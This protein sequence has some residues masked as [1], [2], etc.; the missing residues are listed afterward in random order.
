VQKGLG[1]GIFNFNGGTLKSGA[2]SATFMTGLTNAYVYGGGAIIDTSGGDITIGQALLAP[3][4]NGVTLG[5]L[6][7]TGSGFIAPPIVDIIGGGGTGATA[8]ATVDTTTGI[9]TGIV[10]T[11]PGVGYT[12]GGTFNFTGGGGTILSTTGS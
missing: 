6:G 2:T 12:S 9:L 11:N 8:I 7:V 10:M 5:T 3:T 4:G 1:T